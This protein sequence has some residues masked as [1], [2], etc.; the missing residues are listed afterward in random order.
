MLS[1][2]FQLSYA[3]YFENGKS[4]WILP[5]GEIYSAEAMRRILNDSIVDTIMKFAAE[6][7]PLK[8]LDIEIAVLCA[9][10]LTLTGE[11]LIQTG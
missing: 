11:R 7:N 3:E 4:Y 9:I 10:R 8:L 1:I 5:T 6:F 2:C